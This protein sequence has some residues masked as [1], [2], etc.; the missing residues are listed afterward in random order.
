MIRANPQLEEIEMES[1]EELTYAPSAAIFPRT[2]RRL[3]LFEVP[4]RLCS[5]MMMAYSSLGLVE[6]QI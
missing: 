2:L 3:R 4:P 1:L 6:M 5:E